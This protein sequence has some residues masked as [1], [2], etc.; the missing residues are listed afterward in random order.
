MS[1]YTFR[2]LHIDLTTRT[3]EEVPTPLQLCEEYL[4]G[5]GFGVSMI[6]DSI[7]CSWDS[8]EMPIIFATGPL[9]GTASPTSGRMAV[10][11]R[12][13]LTGTVFDCS[14]G[15]RFGTT[16]KRAGYDYIRIV[17]TA[18]RLTVLFPWGSLLDAVAGRDPAGL[19][20]LRGTCRPGAS[21]RFLLE[22]AS[23]PGELPRLLAEGGLDVQARPVAVEA[24]RSLP[25][26]WA[27]KLGY[28]GRPRA[29]WELP[30]VARP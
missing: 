15:G 5:R 4:G 20:K 25:T 2:S 17:G 7:T 30:G 6:S 23:G 11:S 9:V 14:V 3:V 22:L 21:V 1:G 16:L 8:S 18:D 13:P 26:T 19:A 28:S 10:V 27:K 24:V 12:S 29:F